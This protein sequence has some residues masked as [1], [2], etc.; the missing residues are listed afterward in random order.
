MYLAHHD[1]YAHCALCTHIYEHRQAIE[2]FPD[3]VFRP[4]SHLITLGLE[5]TRLSMLPSTID[6]LQSLRTLR[7]GRAIVAD[8]F[9][10]PVNDD[11]RTS[12][13]SSCAT[14]LSF[15]CTAME[16]FVSADRTTRVNVTFNIIVVCRI[17]LF[18][19]ESSVNPGLGRREEREGSWLPKQRFFDLPVMT[20]VGTTMTTAT[21][22][23]E[24]D[25]SDGVWYDD[26]DNQVGR[27]R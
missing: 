8:H 11:D 19:A 18:L 24:D 25:D 13:R 16:D 1:A 9:P 12:Y 6:S 27:Q 4:G 10:L 20:R 3:S 7:I 26:N 15:R 14:D 2:H 5:D 17:L 21:R 22:S 23:C